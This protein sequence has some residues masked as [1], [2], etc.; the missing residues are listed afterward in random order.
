[1]SSA[2]GKTISE[3]ILSAK[4]RQD[5]YA[6]D[7]IVCD[8][9]LVIGTDASSPMAI[10]YFEQ[11]GGA[12]LFDPS[13]VLFAM[14]HYAPPASAKVAAYHDRI[15][16][17]AGRYGGE[18]RD[19][20]EGISFQRAA[21]LGR[22]LPGRLVIGADSHTVTL[23]ALDLFA[24]GVGSSDLAAAM[25]TG[26][27][28]L[29]VPES[30]HVTLTGVR[31]PS[32]TAKDVALEL[33]RVVG[34]EG[35]NYQ[36]LEFHGPAVSSFSLEDRLVISNLGVE[37][38]AKASIFAYDDATD[39]YL[40]SRVSDVLHTRE[41]AVASDTH[42]RY[43]REIVLDV[44]AITPRIALP[45]APDNVVPLTEAAGTRVDM[46]FVGTCTG[47][48]V[49]DFHEVLAVLERCGGRVAPDVQLVL[50]PASAEVN[51]RLL[52]DGTL[53]KLV[54][55][56]ATVTTPGCGACC[57]TSGVIPG[58]GMNVLSTANRNFKARMGNATA[59]IYLASPASCA[60]AAVTGW[61]TDPATL[62]A[63]RP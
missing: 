19:V 11:M 44:S 21:E 33:V 22:A 52:A 20:G 13:K 24:T 16:A 2:R 17:F 27:V 31:A 58:D 12:A 8:V 23:G 48:R 47:G 7:I 45:H 51:E 29:R 40:A 36:T 55:M 53:G 34:A 18:V 4:S 32:L 14:D 41:S 35:A 63:G 6:G 30:I 46:V 50:T 3:K 42:A 39:A 10:D 38:G 61:I 28:W 59:S 37:M 25:I 15:R 1:M 54:A 26:Q 62:T 60:A 9:D 57:G 49:P 5:A 43:A 56:G